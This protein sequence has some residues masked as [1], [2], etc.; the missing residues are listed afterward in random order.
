[1]VRKAGVCFA[2]RQPDG[3]P[4]EHIASSAG[5]PEGTDIFPIKIRGNFS[6]VLS[7]SD[8]V[9][10]MQNALWTKFYTLRKH[11]TE[12]LLYIVCEN[13]KNEHYVYLISWN[14]LRRNISGF[15]L[16]TKYFNI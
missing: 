4:F 3:V 2:D 15:T 5:T 13:Y 7:L 8:F 1:M 14:V 16:I 11:R 6:A 10:S 9:H 12:M